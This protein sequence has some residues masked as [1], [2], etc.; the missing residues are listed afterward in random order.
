MLGVPVVLLC[1]E[2]LPTA[3]FSL[4]VVFAPNAELPIAVRV[5][6]DEDG[7]DHYVIL[8]GRTRL[9][10]L[11]GEGVTTIVVDVFEKFPRDILYSHLSGR[12]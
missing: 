5:I 6:E 9:E 1:N 12:S 7:T 8:D 2:R 10:I 4:A 3:V 11:E